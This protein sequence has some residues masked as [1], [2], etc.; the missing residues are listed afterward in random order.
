MAHDLMAH[1]L[2][3]HAVK[4][5]Q[6]HNSPRVT[7]GCKEYAKSQNVML[8]RQMFDPHICQTLQANYRFNI[9][10]GYTEELHAGTHLVSTFP[11]FGHL[12]V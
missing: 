9:N 8:N 4:Q 7:D 1:D 3:A 11:Y 12:P 5:A 10:T 6:S 2:I